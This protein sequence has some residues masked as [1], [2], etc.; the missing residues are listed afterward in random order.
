MRRGAWLGLPG[1]GEGGE[2]RHHGGGGHLQGGG[3]RH[4]RRGH[5][6]LLRGVLE[7]LEEVQ[8]EQEQGQ[9]QGQKNTQEEHRATQS[10][11]PLLEDARPQAVSTT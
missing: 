5:P 8:V 3:G 6:Q 11:P 1:C 10:P 7:V 4:H 2:G 9:E